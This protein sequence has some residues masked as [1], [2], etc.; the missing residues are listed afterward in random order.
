MGFFARFRR[1][2]SPVAGGTSSGVVPRHRAPVDVVELVQ[3]HAP[4]AADPLLLPPGSIS[5]TSRELFARPR[6]AVLDVETTGLSASTHRIVEIAIVTTDERGVVMDEWVARVNPQGPVGATHIHGITAADVANAP[7]FDQLVGE[8]NARLAGAALCAHNAR[9]DL[10]FLRAE[11]ARVGWKMPYAPSLCTLEAAGHHLPTLERRR[12]SDCCWAI[13]QPLTQAHS[14]LGDAKATA[15][16]LAAFLDARLGFP[17]RPSD[18]TILDEAYRIPWPTEPSGTPVPLT[19]SGR[20]L[21]G[22]ALRNI[23][24]EATQASSKPLVQLVERFSLL[25]ALDAGAPDGAIAYVEKLAEVLEDGVLTADEAQAL[26]E[27][28]EIHELEPGDIAA[29]HQAFVFALAH[30]AVADGKVTRAEKSELISVAEVLGVK[31]G[32]VSKILNRAEDVRHGKLGAGLPPLPAGW[33][34]GEPLHVGDRVVFT[35]CDPA[36]REL[37]EDGSMRAGVRLMNN[38]ASTTAMLVSDGSMD[39]TKMAKARECRTR[40]VSPEQYKVLLDHIQPPVARKSKAPAATPVPTVSSEDATSGAASATVGLATAEVTPAVIR[41][42]A[43][44]NGWEVGVRGRLPAPLLEA[45]A[46]HFRGD[47]PHADAPG[48]D[49]ADEAV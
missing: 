10:A 24:R 2:A 1:K 39:G 43:R 41:A 36:F 26:S 35:G 38:V 31:A 46:A 22:Q 12:L 44:E 11:F 15:G 48:P 7:T 32:A 14:A 40:I 42:W 8:L 25:D 21:S 47:G 37:L 45:Y 27:I 17:P 18:L 29:T 19:G 23:A 33:T 4:A 30:E 5:P 3:R 20:R 9:F 13:G 28:A 49:V 34:L 6:F 16:L